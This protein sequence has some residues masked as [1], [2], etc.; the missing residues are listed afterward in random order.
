M[1]VNPLNEN[2]V[3]ILTLYIRVIV[4]A[5]LM[6]LSVH[7]NISSIFSR[8]SRF[9]GINTRLSTRMYVNP[10]NENMHPMPYFFNTISTI[11][12]R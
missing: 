4:M 3:G 12:C 2:G 1:H 10:L 11:V 7:E 5:I 8:T 6:L 9:F